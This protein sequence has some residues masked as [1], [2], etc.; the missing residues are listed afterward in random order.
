[1]RTKNTL[2]TGRRAM[3]NWEPSNERYVFGIHHDFSKV[4]IAKGTILEMVV[5]LVL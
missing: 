3:K 5:F 4:H 2:G 1:M